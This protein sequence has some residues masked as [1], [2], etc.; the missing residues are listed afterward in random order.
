MRLQ[1]RYAFYLPSP[2]VRSTVAF[3]VF[4]IPVPRLQTHR[5]SI[6]PTTLP[7]LVGMPLYDTTFHQDVPQ[8][9]SSENAVYWTRRS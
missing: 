1:P 2:N 9:I 7:F 6:S 8:L 4:P 3:L 5:T